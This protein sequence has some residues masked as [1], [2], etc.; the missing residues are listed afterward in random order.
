MAIFLNTGCQRAIG[1]KYF[2][3]TGLQD[4]QDFLFIVLSL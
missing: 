3:L 1:K 4:E 2:F